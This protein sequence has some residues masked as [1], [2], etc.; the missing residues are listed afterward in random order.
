MFKV[1]VLGVDQ[2]I[3]SCGYALVDMYIKDNTTY[4]LKVIESGLISTSSKKSM[5]NRTFDIF[6]TLE[7]LIKENKPK[8]I[9]C[10]KLFFNSS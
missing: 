1:R 2:G 7:S 5:G 3:A 10:E 9:G 4:E 8:I 6:T